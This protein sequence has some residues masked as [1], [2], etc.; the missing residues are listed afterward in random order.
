MAALELAAPSSTA[1][2]DSAVSRLV[3]AFTPRVSHR[4]SLHFRGTSVALDGST[5]KRAIT[6][7]QQWPRKIE[8]S[9][10]WIARV[11]ASKGGLASH[12]RRREQKEPQGGESVDGGAEATETATSTDVE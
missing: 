8:A 4:G 7:G 3:R 2:A 1:D 5:G 9:H 12:R 11:S 6:G 10:L